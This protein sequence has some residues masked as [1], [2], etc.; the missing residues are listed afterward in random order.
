MRCAV[1]VYPLTTADPEL[2]LKVVQTMLSGT[3]DVRLAVDTKSQYLVAQARPGEHARI[4]ELINKL[5][6][7]KAEVIEPNVTGKLQSTR[8][9]YEVKSP[10]ELI[11]ILQPLLAGQSRIETKS[12]AGNSQ[13]IVS[14]PTEQQEAIRALVEKLNKENLANQ[15]PPDRREAPPR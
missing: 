8:V 15:T 4:R 3:P 11:K 10:A 14:A 9:V 13:L 6:K 5:D 7:P 12:L 2:T 1:E